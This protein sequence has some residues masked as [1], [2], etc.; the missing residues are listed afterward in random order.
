MAVN[1]LVQYDHSRYNVLVPTTTIQQVS[2]MHQMRIETV[3]VSPDPDSGDVYKVGSRKVGNQWQDIL[4]LAKPALMRIAAAAGIVWSW[5][6]SMVLSSNRDYVLYQ[7]VGAIRKPDGTLLPIKAT[8][9]IDLTVIEE[10]TMEANLKKAHGDRTNLNGMTPEAWAAAQTKSNMIQWR[11]NKLMRAETGAMLRVVRA[12]L[13]MKMQYSPDELRKPFA[14]PRIDFAPDYTDASVR[15]IM[16]ENGT[17]A[18]MEMF[19]SA[20]QRLAPAQSAAV[21]QIGAP[22]E[23]GQP[24]WGQPV[25]AD[26]LIGEDPTDEQP[27]EPSAAPTGESQQTALPGTDEDGPRCECGK[28]V[29][30]KVAEYSRKHFGGRVLCM[31]CQKGAGK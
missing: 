16:A 17:R 1:A 9:E 6:D 13:G 25:S 26:E 19:G 15:Q 28:K 31:D 7:A 3:A 4:S 12:L 23:G 18:T 24:E 8:K 30:D 2:P 21:P 14:V 22:L 29:S 27:A 20:P 10:E 5:R 11:K